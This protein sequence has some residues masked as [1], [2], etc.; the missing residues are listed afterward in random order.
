MRTRALVLGGGG[1]VGVAWESGLLAGLSENGVDLALAD[2]I[3]GTSA[4]SFVGAQVATGRSPSS[5]VDGILAEDPARILPAGGRPM[6]VPDMSVLFAKMAEAV[7]GARP[8]ERVRAEIGAWALNAETIMSEKEFIAGLGRPFSGLPQDFWPERPY[9]CTA[10]DAA[11]GSFVLWNRD[12]RVGL[13]DAVAS[14]CAAPGLFP[15][16]TIRGRRYIDGGTRSPTNADAAKGYDVV[17][18][19]EVRGAGID[20]AMV[21]RFQRVLD[22]ELD[23]LRRNG[24]R[25]ELI[26]PDPASIEAFGLNLM[27]P[28]KR[29]DAATAGVAQGRASAD[30]LRQFWKESDV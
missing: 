7:S 30:G 3:I 27:D 23:V 11:D 21:E 16:I 29:K 15:P 5:I 26:A 25:V 4:G 14:S 19:V 22:R 24:A 6:K 8:A 12:S 2:L 13:V 18:V 20:P 17:A 28:G 10:V 1:M 9:A